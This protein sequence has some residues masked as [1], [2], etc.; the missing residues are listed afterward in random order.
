MN[1]LPLLSF[2]Q[3]IAMKI[4][5]KFLLKR[6]L[7]TYIFAVFIIV[8]VIMVIDFVEKNDNF[9]QRQ[10]PM[11]AILLQY[12]LNLAPYWANYIS[13]LMIFISTVFFTAKLAS[14]TEI[15]A[16]LSSGISFTRIMRPYVIGSLLV[17]LLS[18]VMVGWVLPKANKI[19]LNFENA[20][21]H[22]K[23]YFSDRNFHT[24]VAPN[25][26]AYMSSY[27]NE[28]KTGYDFTLE[29]IEDGKLKEKLSARRITW[30]DSTS[31]W[32]LYDYRIRVLGISKDKLTF[33][34]NS[35]DTTLTLTPDD[36]E[37]SRARH[38][39]FTIPELQKQI[40][41]IEL[42]GSEGIAPYQIEYYQRFATPFAVVILS[43]MG[44]IVAARKTRGGVGVQIAIGFVLAFVYILFYIMS[45]GIAEAGNMPALLAV[46]LPNIV[47]GCIAGVM[48]FTVPR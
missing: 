16:M 24:A 2:T 18:F 3:M 20:Y 33:G 5:D 19:R 17:A 7:T 8:L 15:I 29:K 45:K 23:F 14:H 43:I 27:N 40:R 44:L 12:Y 34:Q 10:A 9:I 13:P 4:L 47:F 36:F 22:E 46:W 38:E 41:L 42:R 32:Q 6:F 39:T 35:I 1:V 48:Y 26:Y 31:R 25:V 30:N 11:R 28:S 37:N 21:V